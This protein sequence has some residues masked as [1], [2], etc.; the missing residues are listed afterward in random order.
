MPR[1]TASRP[2]AMVLAAALAFGLWLPTLTVPPA[3]AQTATV[4]LPLYA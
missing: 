1:T 2:L 3:E 4:V